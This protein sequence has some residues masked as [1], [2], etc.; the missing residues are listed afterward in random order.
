MIVLKNSAAVIFARM[1]SSRLPGKSLLP[2]ANGFLLIELIIKQLEKLPGVLV[3]LATSDHSDDDQLAETAGKSGA[4]VFRGD[5][6]NVAQRAASCIEHFRLDFFSRI[7]GDSPFVNIE[8]LAQ[9]FRR[10]IESDLDLITNLYPRTFPYGYSLEV[11]KAQS[12][13]NAYKNFTIAEQEHITAYFY[14]H[15]SKFKY[16]NIVSD[17]PL[18]GDIRLTI[19]TVE[20]Y[21]RINRLFGKF[22]Q[23]YGRSLEEIIKAYK[24]VVT[25]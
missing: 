16:E 15:V 3:I 2:L 20:D 14:N 21:D 5:L 25:I 13:L 4:L 11:I 10:I 23:L 1:S 6:Q 17:V 9:G 18:K 19:D 8:H 12:F 22:P 7:N 24:D